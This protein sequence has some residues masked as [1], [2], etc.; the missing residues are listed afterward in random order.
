MAAFNFE[1]YEAEFKQKRLLQDGADL[2][3]ALRNPEDPEE[4]LLPV[5]PGTPLHNFMQKLR[6][7]ATPAPN[8]DFELGEPITVEQA[9]NRCAERRLNG[10]RAPV[11]LPDMLVTAGQRLFFNTAMQQPATFVEISRPEAS[12]LPSE[13]AA[14]HFLDGAKKVIDWAHSLPSLKRLAQARLYTETMARHALHRLVSLY[15]PEHS[16]LVSDMTANEMANYLIS[17]ETNRDKNAYRRKELFELTRKP[18]M[19]LRAPLT[20]ARRLIDMI[21]PANRPEMAMQRSAAWRTAIISFL[22]DDMAVPIS[23]RLKIANEKCRPISDEELEAM[24]YQ[25]DEAYRK[26]PTWP[27]KYGRN[28]GSMLALAMIQFNSMQIANATIPTYGIPAPGYEQF[29]FPPMAGS[30]PTVDWQEATRQQQKRTALQEATRLQQQMTA[31]QEAMQL[32]QYRTAQQK[33]TQLQEQ[34]QSIE[35]HSVNLQAAQNDRLSQIESQIELLAV[36]VKEGMAAAKSLSR[37]GASRENS[38]TRARNPSRESEKTRTESYKRGEVRE[39][40]YTSK[41]RRDYSQ[42]RNSAGESRNYSASRLHSEKGRSF[43]TSGQRGREQSRSPSRQQGNST[44]TSERR[45]RR[46][47]RSGSR[48]RERSIMVRQ[49]YPK[50]KKGENCSLDYDPLKMKSCS[51]C[52]KP[53]HH[54]FECYKYERYSIKKCSVC[55][56]LHHFAGDCKELEKFPPKGKE[57]NSSKI[58]KNW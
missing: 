47:D 26:P 16:H 33:A 51:K 43:S 6:T 54:E 27:L 46:D 53:G 7:E 17:T 2:F 15:T 55:D 35:L 29:S 48:G 22:P 56:R 8:F 49:T 13:V 11:N 44:L 37:K 42:N 12:D 28:I 31:Q 18:D 40:R 39:D 30:N 1:V 19:D 36:T 20:T 14:C 9:A 52:G 4:R 38:Q 34:S 50:M 45:S 5:E 3:G 41:E 58:I 57:L 10:V 21:F 24:A 23:D 32:Q 25:A